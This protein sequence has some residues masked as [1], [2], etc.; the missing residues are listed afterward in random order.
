MSNCGHGCPEGGA[1]GNRQHVW[2]VQQN[3]RAGSLIE[4]G[5]R[6]YNFPVRSQDLADVQRRKRESVTLTRPRPGGEGGAR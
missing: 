6:N 3:M 1:D 2:D 5:I 4:A